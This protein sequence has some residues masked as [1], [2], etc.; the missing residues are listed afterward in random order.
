MAPAGEAT[1]SKESRSLCR[2]DGNQGARGPVGTNGTRARVARL[3]CAAVG[4]SALGLIGAQSA[5]QAAPKAPQ[6]MYYVS[7]GDSY[8]IGYQPE[9]AP[10]GPTPGYTAYVAKKKHMTL[11]N[12]GCGG[13]TTSSILNAVGCGAPAGT[14]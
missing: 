6:T 9:P 4:L 8:S 12:F 7:L 3:L 2:A 11:E 14:D 13:A 5:G 1:T 10:G